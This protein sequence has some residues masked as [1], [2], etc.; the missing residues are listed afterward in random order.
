[1]GHNVVRYRL[2]TIVLGGLFHLT[3]AQAQTC[4]P[5][6]ISAS[7]PA[8]RFSINA[9]ETVADQQSGIMWKQCSE[10]QS[11][12]GCAGDATAFTWKAALDYVQR[13]NQRGGYAGYRDWRLPNIKELHSIVE[14]QCFDPAIN[15]SIFS[16]TPGTNYWTSSPVVT[17]SDS[18]YLI[19]FR[20]GSVGLYAKNGVA[21]I[22][23]VRS[24]Q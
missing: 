2:M 4:K 18:A 14:G 9:D 16:A 5:S 24:G 12:G 17:R 7:A 13:F 22:R 3:S 10:G 19:S 20:D 8:N 15:I 11:E 1:M 21:N 23:L 6:S